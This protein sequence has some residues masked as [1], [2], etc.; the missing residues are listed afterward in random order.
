MPL[1]IRQ[2]ENLLDLGAFQRNLDEI[3]LLSDEIR[4]ATGGAS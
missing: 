3:G 2:S 4:D 1:G